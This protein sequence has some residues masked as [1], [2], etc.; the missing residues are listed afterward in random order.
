MES[1]QNAKLIRLHDRKNIARGIF[2]GSNA[3]SNAI[4]YAEHY[5][6]ANDAVRRTST[7]AISK[8]R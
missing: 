6:R 5:S 1:M 3:V 4:G 8:S 7:R 2:A